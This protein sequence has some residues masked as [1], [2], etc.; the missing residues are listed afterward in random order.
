MMDLEGSIRP[1][2]YLA[3]E[4]VKRNYDVSMLSPFMS[5]KVEKHLCTS[6]ITPFNLRSKLF[7]MRLG[8]SLVWFE[9]WMREAFLKLNSRHVENN[10]SVAINFSQVVSLPAFVWYLQ[11][12]PSF[13]LKDI[14]K[15]LSA[16][17]RMPYICLK[18]AIEFADKRLI[19]R[20]SNVS[21]FI[22]ANSKFCASMYSKE[23]V[24]V[25]DVI[26][27]P[28]D[29]EIFHPSTSNPSSDYVLTYFGK[30]TKFS[31]IKAVADLDVKIRAF[32][33]K[34]PFVKKNM[35]NHPNIEFLGRVS[36]KELVDLYSNAS[37]TFF[38]FTHE[39]FGY[40]PLESMACGTP[41]LTYDLQ[42]P[43]E[44]VID[45]KVGWLANSDGEIIQAAAD[46]WKNGYS[47]IVRKHCIEEAQKL[48]KKCYLEKWLKILSN[49]G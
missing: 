23:G 30:E 38:P 12:P 14:E 16:G 21:S 33:S 8:F 31:V 1:A 41:V 37:F 40:V 17:F 28:V 18:P 43:G 11:G 15:E 36:T 26:Y 22:V 27:P 7:T 20:L 46:I 45:G 48:D 13:A 34:V 6:D 2:L 9:S 42:G 5:E 49:T 29:C 32:G 35:L 44:Y 3:Q 39:P 10:S 19:K 47:P 25:D 24:D 4:L